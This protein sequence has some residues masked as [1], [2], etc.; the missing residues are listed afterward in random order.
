MVKTMARKRLVAKTAEPTRDLRQPLFNEGETGELKS[1]QVSMDRLTKLRGIMYDLD[2]GLYREG[3]LLPVVGKT[4]DEFYE[5]V[6]KGWL[7]NHPVLAKAE[8]RVSGTGLHAIL[9]LDEPVAFSGAGDRRRWAGIVKVVQAALPIDPD[10]PGILATTRA[11][12]SINAKNGAEVRRIC[13]G[14]RITQAEILSLYEEMVSAPFRTVLQILAGQ[15]SVSPCPLCGVEDTKLNADKYRG[16]C[17]GSCGKVGV[18]ELYDAVL[19]PR[20]VGKKVKEVS[21]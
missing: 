4:P 2:P 20:S 8:V 10:Q 7:S 5:K 16:Y 6:G 21:P 17:Y 3:P 14:E 13:P 15:E 18:E 12:G 19:V 1:V 9:W 11:I